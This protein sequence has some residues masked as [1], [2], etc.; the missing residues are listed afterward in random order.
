VRLDRPPDR[1]VLVRV[2]IWNAATLD[3]ETTSQHA[4]IDQI[5]TAI[6]HG[7]DVDHTEVMQTA[8][9]VHAASIIRRWV[10]GELDD[11]EAEVTR[12]AFEQWAEGKT[13][14]TIDH[15]LRYLLMALVR[16]AFREPPA[17]QP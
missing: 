10:D 8:F 12:V 13:N 3:T 17:A 2:P 1:Y 14:A 11:V 4:R 7:E 16:L 5:E 6:S 15:D 9:T